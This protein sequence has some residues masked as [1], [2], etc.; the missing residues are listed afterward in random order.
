MNRLKV[1]EIIKFYRIKK[2]VTQ[3]ELGE[4][5]GTSRNY[6]STLERCKHDPKSSFLLKC[7]EYLDIP[8][9]SFF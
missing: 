6:V 4:Y 2:G 7:I 8:F 1:G 5:C 9:N 3:Q